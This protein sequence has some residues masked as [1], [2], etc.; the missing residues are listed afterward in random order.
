MQQILPSKKPKFH[1]LKMY[2]MIHLTYVYNCEAITT[3][4]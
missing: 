4:K 3:R 2:N 1:V